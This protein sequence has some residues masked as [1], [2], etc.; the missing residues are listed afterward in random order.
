MVKRDKILNLAKGSKS[1]L[2]QKFN[3]L[4]VVISKIL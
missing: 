1:H 3:Q 4:K 2:L